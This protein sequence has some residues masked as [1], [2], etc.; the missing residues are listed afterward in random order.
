MANLS[1]LIL[2]AAI[3]ALIARMRGGDRRDMAHYAM[4]FGL[5]GLVIGSFVG[6]AV[7]RNA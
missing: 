6:V 5:I 4:V 2:G 1:G 3:G 7:L